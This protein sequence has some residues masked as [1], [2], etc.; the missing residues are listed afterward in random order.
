MARD[1]VVE[2][3]GDVLL[4]G[5]DGPDLAHQGQLVAVELA[6]EIGADGAPAIAA[7]VAAVELLRAE[8]EAGVGVRADDQR[9]VPVPA[10]GRIALRRLRLDG[11][12]LAGALVEAHHAAVLHVGVDGVR[13]LRIDA[14]IESV[15]AHGDEAV[16]VGD[17]R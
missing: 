12:A 14:R 1:V 3:R 13:V 4:D 8:V 17:V 6:G 9:R 10:H 2:R 11:D 15:A 5:I 16:G 7:V